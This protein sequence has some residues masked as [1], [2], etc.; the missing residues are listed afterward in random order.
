MALQPFVGPRPL[1]QFLTPI[2]SRLDS[3]YG[4]SAHR[5]AAT[6]T[7]QHEHRTTWVG[8]Q[9][10]IPVFERAKTV[11]ALDRAATWSASPFHAT[12]HSSSLHSVFWLVTLCSS[13]RARRFKTTFRLLKVRRLSHARKQL[14]LQPASDGF[15]FGLFFDP[16]YVGDIFL[17]NVGLFLTYMALQP[18]RP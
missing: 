6:Y 16:E 7:G 8:F 14:R 12:G 9:P 3:L 2:R 13:D 4:G 18:W 10:T 11:H 5:K 15:L 1:F 17:R